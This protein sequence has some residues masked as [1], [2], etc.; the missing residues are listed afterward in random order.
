[1]NPN[2]VQN[3]KTIFRNVETNVE[4]LIVSTLINRRKEMLVRINTIIIFINI[5]D[6]LPYYNDANKGM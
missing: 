5:S 3:P 6:V 1:M 2:I 4:L